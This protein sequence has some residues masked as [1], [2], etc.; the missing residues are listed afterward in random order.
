MTKLNTTDWSPMIAL[1]LRMMAL[2]LRIADFKFTNNFIICD[3]LPDMEILFGIDIQKTLS[4]SYALDKE[5]KL[6]HTEGWQISH[7]H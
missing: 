5:K 6:L 4:L 7:L 2:W 3:R 1:T